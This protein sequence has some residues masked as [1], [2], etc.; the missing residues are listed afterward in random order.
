MNRILYL[1]LILFVIASCSK[2]Q[3]NPAP[4]SNPADSA[5]WL[6]ISVG[7]SVG[8][9]TQNASSDTFLIKLK[10]PGIVKA[11][12]VILHFCGRGYSIGR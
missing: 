4:S 3:A 11:V 12:P 10:N 6:T 2:H 8:S 7:D 5:T 9:V 1:I